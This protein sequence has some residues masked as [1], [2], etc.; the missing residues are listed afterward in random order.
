MSA[1]AAA[2]DDDEGGGDEAADDDDDAFQECPNTI[3][4]LTNI[5]IEKE[6]ERL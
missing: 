4:L 5:A 2:A 3:M 1:V 6:R